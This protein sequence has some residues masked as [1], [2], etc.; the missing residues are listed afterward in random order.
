MKITI[1]RHTSVAVEPGI[2]YGQSDVDVSEHFESEVAIIKSRL[3]STHFDAIYSSPLIRCTKLAQYC[4]YSNALTDTRLMELNFG[5][6]EMKDWNDINDPKLEHWYADWINEKPTNGESFLDQV[7]RVKCFLN[8]I[9]TIDYQ[10]IA[11]F[12]HAGVIRSIGVILNQFPIE[13]AF[14]FKVEYGQ[15]NQFEL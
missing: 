13:K 3:Q 14:E 9:Q 4:G 6:W 8:N 12:T 11:I 10:H 15:I 2:C 1:V 5:D 7:K